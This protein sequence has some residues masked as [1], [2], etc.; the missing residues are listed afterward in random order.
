MPGN[1]SL[2]AEKGGEELGPLLLFNPHC[3]IVYTLYEIW[4]HFNVP[5]NI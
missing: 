5:R 3:P 2:E 1:I 4:S